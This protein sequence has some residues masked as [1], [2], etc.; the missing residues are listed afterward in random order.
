[1]K[2]ATR[3]TP[4]PSP[5]ITFDKPSMTDR[6]FREECDINNIVAR[7]LSTGTMPPDDGSGVFGDFADLPTDLMSTY[8]YIERA[9]ERFMDLPSDLRL[10]FN[11]DPMTLL[12]ALHDPSN[13][14]LMVEYG[15]INKA[16][17]AASQSVTEPKAQ[18]VPSQETNVATSPSDG[19]E[20]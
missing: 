5:S 13:Y 15:L 17:P 14:D 4:P 16:A 7:C 3:Y 19:A 6:S 10:K 12:Q 20:K 9:G 8:D 18:N 2:F 11:N 1:M